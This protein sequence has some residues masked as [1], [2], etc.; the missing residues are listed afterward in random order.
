[1]SKN[2]QFLISDKRHLNKLLS[3]LHDAYTL[4]SHHPKAFKVCYLD[5]Y[6][7]R[8]WLAGYVLEYHEIRGKNFLRWRGLNEAVINQDIPLD[9]C[10]RFTRDFPGWLLPNEFPKLLKVRALLPRAWS[11][12]AVTPYELLNKKGHTV[13]RFEVIEETTVLANRHTGEELPQRLEIRP[14]RGHDNVLP[15]IISLLKESGLGKYATDP[16]IRLLTASGKQPGDYSNKI[17]NQFVPHEI[18]V[19]ACRQI[20]L[21]MMDTM[22]ANEEG[23][24]KDIDTEYLHDFRVSVRRSRSLLTS[25]K[26]V[27]P[28]DV[29]QPYKDMFSMLGKSTNLLR[30]MDVYLIAFDDYQSQLPEDQ[31][32]DLE[33]LREYLKSMRQQGLEQVCGVLKSDDYRKPMAALRRYLNSNL[34]KAPLSPAA[35]QPVIEIASCN[36]WKVYK[37]LI[38]QGDAITDESPPESLHDLRKTAKKLRYLLEFFKTL[39]PEDEMLEVVNRLK[40]LQDYLGLYQDYCVQHDSLKEF[41]QDMASAGSLD[42]PTAAAIDYLVDSLANKQHEHRQHMLGPYSHFREKSTN[43]RFRE[44]FH[45][46]S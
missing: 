21:S 4:K 28:A 3:R 9:N 19:N 39:Y 27:F 26:N 13:C 11:K 33:P 46:K 41:E 42:S 29:I 25:V 7:W 24:R 18:T 30:D 45:S 22:K 23:I 32:P 43:Q 15:D 14:V 12:K 6:D 37:K 17:N 34:Q 10:P 5:S 35:S 8:M 1:V 36:I 40:E 16:F 44:L 20:L 31:Q 38:K 2:L